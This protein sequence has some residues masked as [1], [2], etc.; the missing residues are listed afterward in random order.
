MCGM[1]QLGQMVETRLSRGSTTHVPQ[2]SKV[3]VTH[4]SSGVMD[5]ALLSVYRLVNT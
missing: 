1:R 4:E 5:L 3:L 2:C